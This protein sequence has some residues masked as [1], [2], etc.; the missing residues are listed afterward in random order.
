LEDYDF[1]DRYGAG[2]SGAGLLVKNKQEDKMYRPMDARVEPQGALRGPG[3][4]SPAR[5]QLSE[6]EAIGEALA[7][8]FSR[9]DNIGDR[10]VR[11]RAQL[12]GAFSEKPQPGN[13]AKIAC[14]IGQVEAVKNI[15]RG[16][17]Y[18]VEDMNEHMRALE[19]F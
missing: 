10:I 15:I 8:V 6:L 12:F 14:D 9:L 4:N 19:D 13:E 18:K 7:G 17:E 1:S 2:G 3:A 16:L 11:K 5:P